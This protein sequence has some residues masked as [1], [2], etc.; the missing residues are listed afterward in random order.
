[1]GLFDDGRMRAFKAQLKALDAPRYRVTVQTPDDRVQVAVLS[2]ADLLG[3]ERWLRGQNEAGAQVRLR[4]AEPSG[5]VLVGPLSGRQRAALEEDGFSGALVTSLGADRYEVWVR[6]AGGPLPRGLEEAMGQALNAHYSDGGASGAPL[7]G[8]LAAGQEDPRD[9]WTRSA[10][11]Q[12]VYVTVAAHSRIVAPSASALRD[13]LLEH[14]RLPQDYLSPR[15]H[16]HPNHDDGQGHDRPADHPVAS[17]DRPD[18][19]M[20]G[21]LEH[22]GIEQDHGGEQDHGDDGWAATTAAMAARSRAAVEVGEQVDPPIRGVADGANEAMP[23]QAPEQDETLAEQFAAL[24]EQILSRNRKGLD[25]RQAEFAA[26]HQLSRAHP[27]LTVVELRPR[28]GPGWGDGPGHGWPARRPGRLHRAHRR[29]GAGP[30]TAPTNDGRGPR[31]GGR[32]M[33]MG[34][35]F[36]AEEGT[37]PSLRGA[38]QDK[39]QRCTNVGGP[40]PAHAPTLC[41]RYAELAVPVPVPVSFTS[42]QMY[43]EAA[44]EGSRRRRWPQRG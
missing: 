25:A 5:L 15:E 3:Q 11:G 6:L 39:G 43:C 8:A 23:A 1:M 2:A 16:D 28:P 26:A 17:H 9:P 33:I 37:Q 19:A 29:A 42:L 18:Q 4:P 38:R 31:H 30:A 35:A 22:S 44:K 10:D 20:V 12:G 7:A 21:Q 27:H 34:A 13:E 14:M 36:R 32:A 24:R 40:F 41:R